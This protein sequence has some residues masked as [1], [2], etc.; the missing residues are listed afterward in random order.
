MPDN[1]Y[2]INPPCPKAEENERIIGEMNTSSTKQ[3]NTIHV[4][5]R[6]TLIELLVV[7]A[8]IAILAGMLL[9][10]IS[11]TKETVKMMTCVSNQKQIMQMLHGYASDWNEYIVPRQYDTR[12]MQ[13]DGSNKLGGTAGMAMLLANT[14]LV[15]AGLQ[16]E[17]AGYAKLGGSLVPLIFCGSYKYTDVWD[18]HKVKNPTISNSMDTGSLRSYRGPGYRLRPGYSN[19]NGKDTGYE[20]TDFVYD[21][22][23]ASSNGVAKSPLLYMGK[24]KH[25]SRKAY[26]IEMTLEPGGYIPGGYA[27]EKKTVKDSEY[28][29]WNN[30]VKNGRHNGKVTMG[31]L[32]GHADSILGAEIARNKKLYASDRSKPANRQNSILSDYC[33]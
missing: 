20:G 9:P 17:S 13:S 26:S 33:D 22:S 12:Q 23:K 15:K 6:F 14:G 1:M 32:D 4:V 18:K 21:S 11:R 19:V 5:R 30:D 16:W 3:L 2:Y 31:Y 27:V 28:P 7:I 8:V 25:A 29:G 10:A 24:I